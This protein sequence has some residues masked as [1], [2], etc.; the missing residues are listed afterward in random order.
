MKI[1]LNFKTPDVLDNLDGE[2]AEE[3]QEVADKFIKYGE[4]VTVEFD[5]EKKTAIVIPVK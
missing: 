3:I 4:L 5:T 2:E 1:R